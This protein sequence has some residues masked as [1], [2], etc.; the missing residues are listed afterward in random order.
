MERIATFALW[1]AMAVLVIIMAFGFFLIV[2]GVTVQSVSIIGSGVRVIVLALGA[3]AVF[4]VL[5]SI[6]ARLGAIQTR[7]NG[8]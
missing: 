2:R 4:A 7:L 5:S 6:R 3:F 8:R 1:T